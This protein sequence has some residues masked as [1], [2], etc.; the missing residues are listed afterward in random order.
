VNI[1]DDEPA[2]TA[3]WLPVYSA[4]IGAP[5]PGNAGKHAAPMGRPV[6]NAKALSLGWKPQV[7][8]WRTGFSRADAARD[9]AD[10]ADNAE[11]ADVK[12]TDGSR[13]NGAARTR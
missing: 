13:M 1:V 4:A 5:T 10:N 12:R 11:P 7:A 6:S 3:D 8:S 2:T 9:N